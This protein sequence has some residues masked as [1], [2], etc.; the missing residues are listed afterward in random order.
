MKNLTN[1]NERL[2]KEVNGLMNTNRSL[3]RENQLL[4]ARLTNVQSSL[5]GRLFLMI[6][7]RILPDLRPFF[8]MATE[9]WYVLL[10][11]FDVE[12]SSREISLFKDLKAEEKQRIVL[13]HSRALASF[14]RN[15]Q[16][17]L[18]TSSQTSRDSPSLSRN[19]WLFPSKRPFTNSWMVSTQLMKWLH[20]SMSAA[21]RSWPTLR[22]TV[23]LN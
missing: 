23:Y 5:V 8:L 11:Y 3:E 19:L 4:K 2:D 7:G 18:F 6:N 1:K 10:V 15:R 14:C 16:S 12:F 13:W 17:L 22:L 21:A 20:S 9:W